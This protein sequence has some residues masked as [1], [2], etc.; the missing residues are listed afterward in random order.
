MENT[1]K[2]FLIGRS[3]YTRKQMESGESNGGWGAT[4]ELFLNTISNYE[5]NGFTIKFETSLWRKIFGC[6]IYKVIAYKN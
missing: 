3:D 5:K 4:T 6:G 1:T 2:G